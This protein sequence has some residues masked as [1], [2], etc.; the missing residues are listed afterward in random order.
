LYQREDDRPE[1][2]RVRMAAYEKSTAPLAEYYRNRGLLIPVLAE[3]APE[4]IFQRTLLSLKGRKPAAN[5]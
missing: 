3:G 1:S 2:I 4:V 5:T